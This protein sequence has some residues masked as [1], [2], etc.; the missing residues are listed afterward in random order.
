MNDYYAEQADVEG[1]YRTLT[2]AEAQ[3]V[4]VL[5]E[6][7]AAQ[8][9]AQVVALRERFDAGAPAFKTLVVGTIAHAIIRVLRNPNGWRQFEL[10]D[11]SF[12]RDSVLSSGL[13]QFQPDELTRLQPRTTLGGAYTIGLG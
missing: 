2:P 8:L 13:L 5:I 4:P 7:A 10:D 12:T 1:R 9:E 11:G 6:D 3:I